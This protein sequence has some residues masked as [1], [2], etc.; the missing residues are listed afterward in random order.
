M[1]AMT[2]FL[3]GTGR[4]TARHRRVVGG[5]RKFLEILA[6]PSTSLRL[7]WSE[8]VSP[9]HDLGLPGA[10]QSSNTLPVPGRIA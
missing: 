8:I 9:G 2:Q 5:L 1:M 3:P 7:C 10:V 6:N 4:G